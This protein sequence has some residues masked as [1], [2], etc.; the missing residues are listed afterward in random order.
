VARWHDADLIVVGAPSG[1]GVGG[2]IH[3]LLHHAHCPVAVVPEPSPPLWGGTLVVGVDGSSANEKALAWAVDTARLV[4][5][6][7][8]AVY[9]YHPALGPAEFPWMDP[10]HTAGVEERSAREM[11]EKFA[12]V[13][14]AVSFRRIN[15]ARVPALRGHATAIDAAALVVGS[16]GRGSIAGRI[17]GRV[18]YQVVESSDRPVIV[19]P[20]HEED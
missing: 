6:R 19:V 1:E 16:R 20:G 13:D 14:V 2:V 11:V 9:A 4:S 15:G 18:P 8:D 12:S 7:V 3:H 17:V 5:G 10:A